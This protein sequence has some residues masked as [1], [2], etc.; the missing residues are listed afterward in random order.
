LV[1]KN[2]I[3]VN[4]RLKMEM[5]LEERTKIFKYIK[6]LTEEDL[7]E[8]EEANVGLLLEHGPIKITRLEVYGG[9]K[10]RIENL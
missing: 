6:Y 7:L 1:V 5:S 2:V 8:I 3:I 10:K 9:V 4:L